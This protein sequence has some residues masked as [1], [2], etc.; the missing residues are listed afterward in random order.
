MTLLR[1][2]QTDGRKN[3]LVLQYY[4]IQLFQNNNVN[5]QT[6]SRATSRMHVEALHTIHSLPSA[7]V[8]DRSETFP[9]IAHTSIGNRGR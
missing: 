6:Q 8:G 4:F 1:S 2:T 5:E 7:N 9:I 3:V